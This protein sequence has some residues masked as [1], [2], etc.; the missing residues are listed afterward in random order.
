M[1]LTRCIVVLISKANPLKIRGLYVGPDPPI[2]ESALALS[3]NGTRFVVVV[4]GVVTPAIVQFR[5]TARLFGIVGVLFSHLL[6]SFRTS[7]A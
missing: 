3:F 2:V 7:R 1:T 6:I 5:E 4:I